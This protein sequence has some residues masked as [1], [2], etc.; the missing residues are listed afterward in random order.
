MTVEWFNRMQWKT[1]N[2][3]RQIHHLDNAG[4]LQ[5]IDQNSEFLRELCFFNNP[6]QIKGDGQWQQLI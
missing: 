5:W 3:Y 1:L 4:M 2:V 6:M